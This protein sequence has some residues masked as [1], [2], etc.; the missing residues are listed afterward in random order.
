MSKS[1]AP[2]NVSNKVSNQS[3]EEGRPLPNGGGLSAP[4]LVRSLVSTTPSSSLAD[5]PKVGFLHTKLNSEWV[6]VSMFVFFHSESLGMW[7][8]GVRL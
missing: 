7:H 1:D 2:K 5:P 8:V 3:C 4:Y 6:T